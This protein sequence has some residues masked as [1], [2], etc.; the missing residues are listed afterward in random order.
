MKDFISQNKLAVFAIVIDIL[1]IAA[2]I[3]SFKYDF[4]TWAAVALG[5]VAVIL[6]VKAK[7]KQKDK[8]KGGNE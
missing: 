2:I 6:N 1:T 8:F 4:I 3:V 5:V 7:R